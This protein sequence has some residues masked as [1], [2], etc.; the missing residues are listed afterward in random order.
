MVFED[1]FS[2][3]FQET[4]NVYDWWSNL[5]WWS[6]YFTTVKRKSLTNFWCCTCFSTIKV[7]IAFIL[8]L[9]FIFDVFVTFHFI[10]SNQH[11]YI[12][13]FS[14]KIYFYP[15][16]LN[17]SSLSWQY[18][19]LLPKSFLFELHS[20]HIYQHFPFLEVSKNILLDSERAFSIQ[21]LQFH[22]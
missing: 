8:S 7:F 1:P 12:W 14:A 22:C 9:F 19:W 13:P 11:F 18:F 15:G 17:V 10:F 4:D 3:C 6:T 2:L 21:Y 5:L 20:W 16:P